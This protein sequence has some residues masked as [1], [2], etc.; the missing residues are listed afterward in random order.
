MSKALAALVWSAAQFYKSI[1]K[2]SKI[3]TVRRYAEAG[4]APKGSVMTVAFELDGQKFA[5]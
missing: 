3:E 1:F 4:P 5:G 2:N